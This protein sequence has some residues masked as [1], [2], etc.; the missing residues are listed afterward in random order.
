MNISNT[1]NLK[2]KVNINRDN[3]YI[4]I[5]NIP[6]IY[7]K[8]SAINSRHATILGK[9]YM[10]M[11][12]RVCESRRCFFS[13][14]SLKYITYFFSVCLPSL[15]PLCCRVFRCPFR[16]CSPPPLPRREAIRVP[17]FLPSLRLSCCRDP[18]AVILLPCVVWW[19][20]HSSA[21][22]RKTV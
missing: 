5:Y 19:L 11:F 1:F 17:L 21:I 18:A 2:R 4:N 8:E 16:C 20:R 7:I 15:F 22:R 14:L 12:T 3:I 9:M 6:L 13:P 10:H